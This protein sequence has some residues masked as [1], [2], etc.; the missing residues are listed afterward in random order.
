MDD[1]V[2]GITESGELKMRYTLI[3]F[4]FAW[5]LSSCTTQSVQPT[6]IINSTIAITTSTPEVGCSLVSSEPAS[7]TV[8]DSQIP[9]VGNSDYIRG[10]E[11]AKITLVEYCDF[12]APGCQ[13]I[14]DV[15]GDLMKA[16]PEDL[17][18]VFRPVPLINVMDKSEMSVKAAVAADAQGKFW[19]M[20]DL[21]FGL[22]AE[23]SV[24]DPA[25]FSDWIFRN[26]SALVPDANKYRTDYQSDEIQEKT[27][28][29][30]E[31]AKKLSIPAVPHI[32]IDGVWQPTTLEYNSLNGTLNLIL[33]KDR[34]FQECPPFTVDPASSYLVTLHMGK[35]DVVIELY[36]DKA[37][38]AVNSFI[39]LARQGWYDGV[40]FH[41]VIPGFMAQ[42]GDPS[43]TGRGNPGYFYKNEDSSLTFDKP[44]VVGVANSGRDTNGSQFFITYAPAPHLNGGFTIFGQVVSGM[45]I[46]EQLT[47]RDPEQNPSQAE[48][49][50]LISVEIEER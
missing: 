40:T 50:T 44:G 49:D 6:S 1:V 11:D 21:L 16:H 42:T 26:A 29:F 3:I 19:E 24:L 41:R 2:S 22:Y 13:A 32:F 33:L 46:L 45:E 14:S 37:P 10:P 38:L 18:I 47:P 15:I 31:D 36:P 20:H 34:Q 7:S 8:S 25:S 48:G 28:S 9:P 17:R 5:V 39:F 23:W 43:G 4:G 12:Q 35:G 30:F 27:L